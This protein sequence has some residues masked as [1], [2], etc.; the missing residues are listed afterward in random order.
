M[1]LGNHGLNLD[2]IRCAGKAARDQKFIIEHRP[3]QGQ[4]GS[5][6]VHPQEANRDT[7]SLLVLLLMGGFGVMGGSL[8]A[9][10]LPALTEPFGVSDDAVGLV[11]G[12]L[13]FSAALTLPFTG[14]LLDILGRRT[15][16]LSCLIL[17]G[18]AGVLC[19]LAPSFGVLLALRFIQGAAASGLIPTG[20]VIIGDRYAGEDRLRLIGMFVGVLAGTAAISPLV[21]G[22]LA[23]Y[24]WR[25]PFYLYGS[26]FLLAGAFWLLVDETAPPEETLADRPTRLGDILIV[27]RSVLRASRVRI[28]F[29]HAVVLYFLLYTVVTFVPLFLVFTRGLTVA[30]A[31]LALSG[32]ALVEALVATQARQVNRWLPGRARLTLGFGFMALGLILLPLCSAQLT[33][34]LSLMVFGTGM[35]IAQPAVYDQA[36]SASPRHIAGSVLGLFNAMKSIGMS[37]APAL[38]MGVYAHLGSVYVFFAAAALGMIWLLTTNLLGL[39]STG[40][41]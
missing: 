13:T 38:L 32:Q 7:G 39:D 6:S 2:P 12:I 15:V 22:V 35:G 26:S 29:A 40:E 16:G 8:V 14:L 20:M 9:P 1:T 4:Q 21:G 31:G 10:G 36:T 3:H 11:L 17:N 41:A 5:Y 24:S 18:A 30:F 25:Y 27:V 34:V 19:A 23:A 33:M 37:L 28:V